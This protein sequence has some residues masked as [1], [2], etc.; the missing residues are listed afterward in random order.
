M[1]KARAKAAAH[2]TRMRGETFT[3]AYTRSGRWYVAE[4]VEA[5]AIFTQG[6]TFEEAR[7]NLVD[8]IAEMLEL[9]PHQFR[10]RRRP[11]SRAG[12]AAASRGQGHGSARCGSTRPRAPL[13]FGLPMLPEHRLL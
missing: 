6:R 13:P 4:L 7:Q 8:L 2:P 11:R 12:G 10:K 1:A 5:T 9:A 3:A